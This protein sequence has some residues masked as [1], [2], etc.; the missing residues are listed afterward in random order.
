[1]AEGQLLALGGGGETEEQNDRIAA[2]Y[3]GRSGKEC[4]RVLF[5]PT[6]T[7]DDPGAIV[8]FYARYSRFA[9][10][11][12]VTFFPWPPPDLSDLV[13]GQ[14]VVLVAGGNTANM[15]AI[16][17]THGFDR[18]LREAWDAGVV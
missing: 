16:W 1:M 18:V 6:A 7:A 15:L 14:D 17:R 4:P 2:Y 11:S 12:H 5:V 13:L 10:P 8:R 3:V 9:E